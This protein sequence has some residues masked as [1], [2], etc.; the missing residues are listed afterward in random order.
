MKLLSYATFVTLPLLQG[1]AIAQTDSNLECKS[2]GVTNKATC[3]T[4][5]GSV[6]GF[7]SSSDASPS[8]I[9]GLKGWTCDCNADSITNSTSDKDCAATF[10]FEDDAQDC[11]GE[12]VTD[13]ATCDTYCGELGYYTGY[14]AD[15]IMFKIDCICGA[16]TNEYEKH[17]QSDIGNSAATNINLASAGV[18]V[19]VG[20]V[21]AIVAL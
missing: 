10:D 1:I 20:L 7:T 15:E 4:W 6:G 13:K 9:K 12:G 19:V 16:E 3:D 8:G 18:V 17:C 14:Y 21:H 11:T 2:E 5:C